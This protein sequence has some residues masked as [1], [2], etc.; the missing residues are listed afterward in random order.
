LDVG[1]T[2]LTLKTQIVSKPKEKNCGGHD[3]NLGQNAVENK[4]RE[5]IQLFFNNSQ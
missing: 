3:P 1:L 4:E 2:T 5:R